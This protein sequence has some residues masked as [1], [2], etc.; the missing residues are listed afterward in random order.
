RS[1]DLDTHD[2]GVKILAARHFREPD[3]WSTLLELFRQRDPSQ[4]TPRVW[5][6]LVK[7]VGP[8]DDGGSYQDTSRKLNKLFCVKCLALV[9]QSWPNS[10]SMSTTMASTVLAMATA[11]CLF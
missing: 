4:L 7:F 9:L 1:D 11:S 8:H 6:S 10:C 5:L 3:M 2:L